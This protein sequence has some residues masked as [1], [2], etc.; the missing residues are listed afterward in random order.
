M[1]VENILQK[2]NRLLTIPF[3]VPTATRFE[4]EIKEIEVTAP[5]SFIHLTL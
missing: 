4:F 5:L 1:T 3:S 2:H